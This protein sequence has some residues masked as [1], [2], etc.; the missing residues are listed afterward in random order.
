MRKEIALATIT[1]NT[2]SLSKFTKQCKAAEKCLKVKESESINAITRKTYNMNMSEK[3]QWFKN[4]PKPQE[5]KNFVQH[6]VNKDFVHLQTNTNFVPQKPQI[7]PGA[8]HA[9]NLQVQKPRLSCF[10]CG[11]FDHFKQECPT[12]IARQK[13]LASLTCSKCKKSGHLD[14]YCQ[15]N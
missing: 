3:P 10:T 4:F 11:S 9:Q 14:R 1:V 13:Y 6:Q 2:K 5:P 12:W 7:Q 15:V 8:Q